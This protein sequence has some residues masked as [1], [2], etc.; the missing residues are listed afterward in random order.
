MS[1]SKGLNSVLFIKYGIILII[2]IYKNIRK[3]SLVH[4]NLLTNHI[5]I[6]VYKSI[7]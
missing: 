4:S 3:T 6:D 2:G 7:D 5:F 1:R